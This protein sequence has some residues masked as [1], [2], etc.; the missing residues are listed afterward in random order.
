MTDKHVT[1]RPRILRQA[2]QHLIRKVGQHQ[3][4]SYVH[5]KWYTET[6]YETHFVKTQDMCLKFYQA[7]SYAVV[8]LVMADFG[9]S[10]V[11]IHFWPAHLAG[12]F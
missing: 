6:V 10:N 1:S 8:H 12:Q 11:G 9:Q 2:R 3:I 4:A 5:H 7:F